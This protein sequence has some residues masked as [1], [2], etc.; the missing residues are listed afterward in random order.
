M[1]ELG[2][3]LICL[4]NNH[5]FGIFNGMGG[6]LKRIKSPQ[7]LH[8]NATVLMEDDTHFKGRILKAQ[9]GASATLREMEKVDPRELREL[10]DWGYALTVHKAQGSEADRVILVEERF[11]AM[12]DETWRRWLYT[13]VTRA[14]KHLTVVSRVRS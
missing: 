11:S 12:D 2:E 1:P 10:F 9:F 4:K 5:D 7:G 8:Y 6:L 3:K 13:G 14:R